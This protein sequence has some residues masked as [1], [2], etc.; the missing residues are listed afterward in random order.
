MR[1]LARTAVEE[2]GGIDVWINNAAVTLRGRF[3][4][5]P[6]QR[7]QRTLEVNVGGVIKGSY[8]A[9]AEMRAAGG[10]GVI[11]NV[12]SAAP[13]TPLPLA[14]TYTAA[15]QAIAG[16]TDA[17]RREMATE[18]DISVCGLFTYF[19]AETADRSPSAELMPAAA[20]V[21]AAAVAEA[22]LALASAEF[23][24]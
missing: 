16:F 18:T 19:V 4:D 9:A 1:V 21:D 22:V 8:A 6:L 10:R 20:M 2:F 12:A 17:L 24:R 23:C 3:S 14:A 13:R 15:E 7:Q 11:I 5:I